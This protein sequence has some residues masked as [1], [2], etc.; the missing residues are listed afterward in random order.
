MFPP[1]THTHRISYFSVTA[2]KTEFW[3]PAGPILESHEDGMDV[4]TETGLIIALVITPAFQIR[5]KKREL[6]K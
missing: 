3:N 5:S 2:L 6:R 1:P 4:V